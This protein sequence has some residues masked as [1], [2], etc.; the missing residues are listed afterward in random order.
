MAKSTFDHVTKSW[1]PSDEYAAIKAAR[2][3]TGPAPSPL[4]CPQ[5]MGDIPEYMSPTGSGVIGSRSA[6]RE[7]LKRHGC[8]EVDPGEYKPT[9]RSERNTA[10]KQR[11][12]N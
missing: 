4:A 1:V 11:L 6:R 9:Y 5:V 3:A 2:D 12:A 8:R 10:R 7:D